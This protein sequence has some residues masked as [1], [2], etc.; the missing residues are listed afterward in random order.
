MVST[1]LAGE[2]VVTVLNTADYGCARVLAFSPDGS[3]LA[4]CGADGRIHLL[5]SA[6]GKA[7]RAFAAPI[8]SVGALCFDPSGG[9][10]GVAGSQGLTVLDAADGKV[11]H[12]SADAIGEIHSLAASPDGTWWA[13][14]G[15]DLRGRLFRAADVNKS[16]PLVS[17]GSA[18]LAATF[19]KDSKRLAAATSTAALLWDIPARSPAR[20]FDPVPGPLAAVAF[21]GERSLVGGGEG[22]WLTVWD[23]KGA[24]PARK[25]AEHAGRVVALAASADGAILASA[26]ADGTVVLR[27]ARYDVMHKL[28]LG[29]PLAAMA[30]SSDGRYLACGVS[31]STGGLMIWR[32]DRRALLS[33][34]RLA[35]VRDKETPKP[36][37]VPS[38]DPQS[39]V[40]TASYLTPTERAVIAEMNLARTNPL[41][42][43][44]LVKDL[45][46]R[47]KGNTFVSA[48]GHK[49]RTKEGVA[50]LDETIAY[51]EKVATVPPLAPSK[52]LSQA[53]MEHAKDTGPKGM[54]GHTGSDGSSAKERIKRYGKP[55]HSSGEN[56]SYGPTTAREIVLQLIIDDGVPSR[57]HRL[58]IFEKSFKLAGVA[59]APHSHYGTM[60]AIDYA[61]GM[62]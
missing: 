14:F 44:K 42:Y 30:F 25:P 39:A 10:L 54:T 35:P 46:A 27:D 29:Q 34:P 50:V 45:K 62:K 36:V 53:A 55:V 12:R 43:A 4:L 48:E 5:D 56:I 2:T 8:R 9:Q 33:G 19:S 31:G 22:G 17:T 21:V 3:T 38:P 60:C 15:S 6:T 58:N 40:I 24:D 47:M 37:T 49:I 51:L 26:G 11:L 52:P 57:G 16:Q 1:A 20:K 28:A 61:G 18:L 41:F 7:L 59:I 13:T 32:L 23:L